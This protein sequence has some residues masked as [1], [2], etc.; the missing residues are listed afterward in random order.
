LRFRLSTLQRVLLST[1]GTVTDI[2]ESYSGEPIGVA[3][4]FESIVLL[5]QDRSELELPAG[6]PVY[7]RH[8]LLEGKTTARRFL[9]AES[10]I[11]LDRLDKAFRD[12]LLRTGKPIGQ[13]MRETRLETFRDILDY[14]QEPAGAIA[15]HFRLDP[16][17][18]LIW[19]TYRLLSGGRPIMLITEKFPESHFLT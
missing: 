6:H 11:V 15:G 10:L 5:E 12:G 1:P 9:Y 8:I 16:G 7:R 4:V 3:K 18:E 17:A 14:G 13:L 19:R 2:L